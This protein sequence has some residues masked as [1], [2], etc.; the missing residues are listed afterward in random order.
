M[1]GWRRSRRSDPGPRTSSGGPTDRDRA[2]LQLFQEAKGKI[3]TELGFKAFTTPPLASASSLDAKFTTS[4]LASDLKCQALFG[5]RRGKPGSRPRRNGGHPGIKPL[6]AND[7]TMLSGEPPSPQPPRVQRP[8]STSMDLSTIRTRLN[9]K[10]RRPPG[11]GTVLPKSDADAWLAAAFAD[12]ERIVARG[13]GHGRDLALY[14]ARTRYLA[15]TRRLGKDVPLSKIQTEFT[16]SDWYEI[17][18]G[19][20]VCF[21]STPSAKRWDRLRLP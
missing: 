17:A 10:I 2:W 19:K 18:S 8:P 16:S 4:S 7:W 6:V 5:R 12:Y 21:S 1:F 11:M 3:N 20:G 9:P 13:E 15:A 14:A